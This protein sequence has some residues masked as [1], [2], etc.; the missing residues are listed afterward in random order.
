MRIGRM[1]VG[2]A[3]LAAAAAVYTGANARAQDAA[4]LMTAAQGEWFEMKHSPT[5]EAGKPFDLEVKLKNVKPGLKLVC[6]FHWFK[7]DGEYGDF[8]EIFGSRKDAENDK[9]YSFQKAPE[10]LPKVAAFVR[11]V[12]HTSPTGNWDDL[13]NK[14]ESDK[15]PVVRR[16]E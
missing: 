2:I 5:I 14:A 4:P 10:S 13:V 8:L 7:E 16:K 6:A 12:L 9:A 1:A 11:V 15:I 3:A